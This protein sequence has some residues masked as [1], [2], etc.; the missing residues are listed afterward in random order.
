[1]RLLGAV[2]QLADEATLNAVEKQQ[3]KDSLPGIFSETLQT[4]VSSVRVKRLL[5]KGGIEVARAMRDILVDVVSE[6]AKKVI[7]P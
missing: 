6:T 7:W 3:L 2:R 4:Q 5:G 1:V